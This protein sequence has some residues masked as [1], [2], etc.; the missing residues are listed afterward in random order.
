ML[1]L[2]LS[3]SIYG[4]VTFGMSNFYLT[5]LNKSLE[6]ELDTTI[7]QIKDMTNDET[8]KILERF[9]IEY[10]VSIIVKNQEGEEIGNYGEIS[11]FLAPDADSS[12]AQ[13]SKGITKN[14][15][16]KSN[17]GTIY[18]LQIFGTKES[19]NIGLKVLNRILPVLG[20]IT[21]AVSILIAVFSL[22]ISLD[23]F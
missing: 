23:Q 13:N 1:L 11:Y 19:V 3:A 21:F 17:E 7:S 6:K 15:I 22:N 4:M 2:T 14:Y 8:Q 18:K 5:E 16:V 20:V 9:A 10:G 12:K